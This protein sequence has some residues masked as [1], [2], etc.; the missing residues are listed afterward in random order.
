VS[1]RLEPSFIMI[2]RIRCFASVVRSPGHVRAAFASQRFL[3]RVWWGLVLGLHGR[4]VR[5]SMTPEEERACIADGFH[6]YGTLYRLV[7][8]TLMIV[9]LG[10]VAAGI[11]GFYGQALLACAAGYLWITANLATDGARLY[12]ARAAEGRPLLVT[13]LFFVTAFLVGFVAT[14]SVVTHQ[15][16][17]LPDPM[18]VLLF[19]LFLAFGIGSYVIELLFLLGPTATGATAGIVGDA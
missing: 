13:F 11:T 6:F 15:H 1:A 10:A 14:A 16:G 8:L 3:L 17:L 19:A 7:A 4:A 9:F 18:N 5:S 12:R 2:Q